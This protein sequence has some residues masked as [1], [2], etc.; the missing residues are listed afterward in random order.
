MVLTNAWLVAVGVADGAVDD[1]E[2]LGTEGAKVV[3]IVPFICL[4]YLILL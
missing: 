3:T 2:P 4:F 1:D